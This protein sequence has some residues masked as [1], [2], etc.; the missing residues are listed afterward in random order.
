MWSVKVDSHKLTPI[1]S[2]KISYLNK[3][4]FLSFRNKKIFF[5]MTAHIIFKN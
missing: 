4:D 1:V 3:K 5:A 2:K